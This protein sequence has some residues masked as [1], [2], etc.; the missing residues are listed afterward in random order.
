MI[1]TIQLFVA[2]VLYQPTDVI[3]DKMTNLFLS[4]LEESFALFQSSLSVAVDTE[5][6][7]ILK[8]EVFDLLTLFLHDSAQLINL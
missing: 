6:L 5:F 2:P 1:A 8:F 3:S 4:Q 7:G